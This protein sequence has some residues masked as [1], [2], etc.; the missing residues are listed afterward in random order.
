MAKKNFLAL[1][2]KGVEWKIYVHTA[3]V[4]KRKFGSDSVAL[5][6]F[7]EHEMHYKKDY[8]KFGAILHELLHALSHSSGN[9]SM[10]STADDREE[11]IAE[12]LELHYFDLGNWTLKVQAFIFKEI[13]R[14]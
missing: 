8:I 1:D 10:N 5:T 2:I 14:R 11:H 4:Y 3:S 12:L 13:E 7:D 9:R 6:D